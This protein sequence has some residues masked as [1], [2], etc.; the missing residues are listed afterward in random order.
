MPPPLLIPRDS[1]RHTSRNREKP[2]L[3]P[4]PLSPQWRMSRSQPVS[5]RQGNRCLWL[6]IQPRCPAA[7]YIDT[8]TVPA[9]RDAASVTLG[10]PS[11]LLP[12]VN[13]TVF[14]NSKLFVTNE[15]DFFLFIHKYDLKVSVCIYR[16][17][18]TYYF[19]LRDR[20]TVADR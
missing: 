3:G 11:R 18:T 7:L 9:A 10:R 17:P 19:I 6:A 5:M 8:A 12:P 16:L 1:A 4:V 14:F 13:R 20:H 15:I 2:T